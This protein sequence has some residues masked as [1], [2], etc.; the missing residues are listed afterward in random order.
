MSMEYIRTHYGVP[1]KKGMRVVVYDKPGV[2]TGASGLYLRVKLDGA[3]HSDIYH[4]TDRVGYLIA[5]QID[6][7]IRYSTGAYHASTQGQ[8]STSSSSISGY[9][10]GSALVSKLYPGAL[11]GAAEEVSRATN[12]TPQVLRFSFHKQR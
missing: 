3:K 12:G 6:I 11:L 10:A 8:K 9:L 1:A 4:P 2:I 5:D 7:K